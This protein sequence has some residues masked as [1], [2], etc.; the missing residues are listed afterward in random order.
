MRNEGETRRKKALRR[1]TAQGDKNGHNS[2]AKSFCQNAYI[3]GD[4]H[5]VFRNGIS[6]THKIDKYL[7]NNAQELIGVQKINTGFIIPL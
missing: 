4:T 6:P 7:G 3:V 2:S 1:A 5:K